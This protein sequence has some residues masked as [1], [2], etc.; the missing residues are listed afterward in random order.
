MPWCSNCPSRRKRDQLPACADLARDAPGGCR[1][2]IKSCTEGG[3]GGRSGGN[4]MRVLGQRR[5]LVEVAV[6][7]LRN[8]TGSSTVD[9]GAHWLR[10]RRQYR[11]R[12]RCT[13]AGF[14][15]F[16]PHVDGRHPEELRWRRRPLAAGDFWSCGGNYQS[17]S[18]A[19]WLQDGL[20][21]PRGRTVLG[22]VDARGDRVGH[23]ARWRSKSA[24]SGCGCC[25]E[26]VD[27]VES[28]GDVRP[29]PGTVRGWT[30]P[31]I[32]LHS[33]VRCARFR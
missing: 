30:F 14:P 1:P 24:I 20:M 5:C 18:G 4:C 10:Q 17:L 33:S 27:G 28:S 16:H 26:A 23:D 8:A 2:R 12:W 19:G 29:A 32:E 13:L 9:D 15:A 7:E 3:G 22:R 31:D 25:R 21:G 6:W 11:R